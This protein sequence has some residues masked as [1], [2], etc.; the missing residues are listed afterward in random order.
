MN[1]NVACKNLFFLV[2]FFFLFCCSN[3]H[4]SKEEN[5]PISLIVGDKPENSKT[6]REHFELETVI[7]IETTDEF[8][9]TD[10]IRRVIHFKDKLFILN[11][12]TAIFIVDYSTGKVETQINRRGIG[13]GESVHI[14]DIAIDERNSQ[15]LVFNDRKKLLYF[16]FEGNFIKQE[17]FQFQ[18]LYE[19][20]IYCDGNLLLYNT[21][22]GYHC[23]PYMI[24]IYNLNDKSLKTIGKKEQL[25]F[26][27]RLYGR[28]I[29]KSKH[30]WFG[31]PADFDLN[32][33]EDSKIESKYRLV[34]STTELTKEMMQ[35]LFTDEFSKIRS[36]QNVMFGIGAIRETEHYMVFIS[37]GRGFFILDKANNEIHWENSVFEPDLGLLLM[38]YYSHDGDDNEI[39]FV[40]RPSEWLQMRKHSVITESISKELKEKVDSFKI[41]EDNNPIL[42]FYKEKL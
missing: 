21:A 35:L 12:K 23:F 11:G 10:V 22:D 26:N 24:D 3:Q 41:E 40:V 1:T 18:S 16:D 39:M 25:D 28:H 27:N 9:M 19:N 32:M 7:P 15:I 38:N 4:N 5:A 42:V 34:P 36:E 14:S 13:P 30:I 33:F 17:T 31:T 2:L 6:F 29:V 37:S 20:I 8:L